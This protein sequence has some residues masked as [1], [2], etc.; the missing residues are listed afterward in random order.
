MPYDPAELVVEAKKAAEMPRFLICLRM[1][2]SF[3][4]HPEAKT[5]PVSQNPLTVGVSGHEY[6]KL[7]LA[8]MALYAL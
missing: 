1:E 3:Q 5:W 6:I 4:R 2:A 7:A 8:S